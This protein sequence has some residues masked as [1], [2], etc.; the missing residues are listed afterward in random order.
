MSSIAVRLLNMVQECSLL[1]VHATLAQRGHK[2]T[3]KHTHIMRKHKPHMVYLL[4][5]ILPPL[6]PFC[7][8][9]VPT[10]GV[11]GCGAHSDYGML[12]ILATDSTPGLQVG[13]ESGLPDCWDMRAHGRVEARANCTCCVLVSQAGKQGVTTDA[14][15]YPL[16]THQAHAH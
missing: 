13:F 6:L 12:T 10:D 11:F 1:V 14:S 9:S 4:V 2:G 16:T 8:V 15:L 5:V 3:P 7:Q